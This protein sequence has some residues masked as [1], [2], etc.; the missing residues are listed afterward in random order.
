MHPQ[1]RALFNDQIDYAR[2]QWYQQELEERLDCDFEFRLAETPL[3]LTEDFE[4]RAVEAA[5]AIVE[6][7]SDPQRIEQMKAAIPERWNTPAM[8]ALPNL[9]QV[10]FAVVNE[11]GTLVPKL[12]ELQGFPS[13]T[14]FQIIQRDCWVDTLAQMEGFDRDWSCWFSGYDRDSFLELARRTI[15]GDHDPAEVILMDIDP[16]RQKTSPDFNATKQLFAVDAVDPT[17]LVKRGARLFR[18]D[19]TP[20]RRI[21]NRVVFDELLKKNIE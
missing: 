6:Q 21:Y 7:L 3:F 10:D 5:T 11:N 13:L 8:D 17:H 1:Y 2:Y 16:P 9:A 18:N 14:S 4:R 19:G 20:V 12:I 15:C